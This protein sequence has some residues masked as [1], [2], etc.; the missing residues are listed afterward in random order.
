M[1]LAYRS[2][3]VFLQPDVKYN[4]KLVSKFINGLMRKGKKALLRKYFMRQWES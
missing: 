4:S 3:E 2:T 1:A